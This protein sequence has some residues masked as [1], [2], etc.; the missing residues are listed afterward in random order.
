MKQKLYDLI[1]VGGGPAGLTSCIYGARNGLKT[2]L[3]EEFACGGQAVNSL[4]IKNYPGFE[5][6]SGF[7]LAQKMENQAKKLG[8]DETFEKVVDFE[9]SD[10]QKVVKTSKNKYLAKAVIL[11]MGAREKRLGLE[12]EEQLIGR[13]VSY[14]A[15]CDGGLYKNK[16]VA[17]VGGGNTAMEDVLYLTNLAK[18]TYLINRSDKFRAEASYVECLMAEQ[19]SQKVEVLSNCVV[20][21]L[22][23]EQKLEKL[24]L[25]NLKTGKL[26]TIDCDGLFIA[27][28]R[29]PNTESLHGKV[30][31][32]EYGY[33]VCD[34]NLMTSAKGVFV[35]GDIRQKSLRQ[36][37]TACADGALASTNAQKYIKTAK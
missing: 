2:L 22:V 1:V 27:I 37:V 15:V 30:D 23:G 25:K 35:A 5:S 36:I 11:S 7:D 9:F 29:E 3:V 24:E 19:Q 4:D 32:D 18:Q 16:I 34:N 31:I 13:G 8:I 10:S 14:C 21:K 12:N 28:G 17:V 26:E 20:N 6:I 33:V